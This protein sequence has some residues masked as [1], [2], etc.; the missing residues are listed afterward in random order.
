LR[1]FACFFT[2]A[3]FDIFDDVNQKY[4]LEN[5]DFIF[6]KKIQK[7]ILFIGKIIFLNG[8]LWFYQ[9]HIFLAKKMF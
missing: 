6:S 3:I 8:L 1:I 5:P 9:G 7:T 4:I 2:K